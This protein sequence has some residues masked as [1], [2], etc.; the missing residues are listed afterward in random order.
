MKLGVV[1]G[2][3][4]IGGE[5]QEGIWINFM[6]DPASGTSGG[7]STAVTDNQG[8]FELTYDPVPNAKG[9]AV[10]KHRVVLNDFRAENFRGGGR[11]PRSRIAEKYMLAVKTPIV[12]EVHEGSQEI[13]IELNDYK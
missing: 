6:P 12:L 11:P 8:G 13:Q 9:A 10:G 7:M 4:T 1:T 5:P 3:L 2:K